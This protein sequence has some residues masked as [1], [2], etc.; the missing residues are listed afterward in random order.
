MTFYLNYIKYPEGDSREIEHELSINQLVDLNGFPLQIPLKTL[1]II[2]YK[3]YKISTTEST[4]KQ[5]RLF[6][7]ELVTTD[8]LLEYL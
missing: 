2:V 1:K 8:E 3:V 7:L 6:H 4:G 5:I